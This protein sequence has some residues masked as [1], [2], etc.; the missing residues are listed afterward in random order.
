MV[1][2]QGSGAWRFPQ[3]DHFMIADR[4]GTSKHEAPGLPPF[5]KRASPLMFTNPID[6]VHAQLT[7]FFDTRRT[8]GTAEIR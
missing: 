6:D 5:V 8:T 1:P 3:A 4:N 2:V 7:H